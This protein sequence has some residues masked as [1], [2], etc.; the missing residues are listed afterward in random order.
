MAALKT[1]T[2]M[3][4]FVLENVDGAERKTMG[5]LLLLGEGLEQKYESQLYLLQIY[6]PG[7]N[8]ISQHSTLGSRKII[9]FLKLVPAIRGYVI[10]PWRASPFQR[11]GNVFHLHVILVAKKTLTIHHT[12]LTHI[13]FTMSCKA[14]EA[15]DVG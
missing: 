8:H 14:D 11:L 1:P 9:D 4:T 2:L 13:F 12:C 5:I 3:S 15:V 7:N 6:P 10:V